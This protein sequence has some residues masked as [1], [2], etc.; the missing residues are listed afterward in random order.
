MS[1]G[2]VCGPFENF[3]DT[4]HAPHAAEGKVTQVGLCGSYYSYHLLWSY[5][6]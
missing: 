5:G 6:F 4:E 1:A 2:I 3:S